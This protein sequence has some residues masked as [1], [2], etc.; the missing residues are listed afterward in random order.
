M[1]ETVF[2]KYSWKTK[3]KHEILSAKRLRKEMNDL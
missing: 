3:R 2:A 1:S